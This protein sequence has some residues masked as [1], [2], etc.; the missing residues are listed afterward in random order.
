MVLGQCGHSICLSCIQQIAQLPTSEQRCPTC[1]ERVDPSNCTPNH[2]L[3]D[4][5]AAMAPPPIVQAPAS[6]QPEELELQ[7]QQE[8]LQQQQAI[9]P[10]PFEACPTHGDRIRFLCATHNSL[11]CAT[12]FL[13]D[14]E[15]CDR[16]PLEAARQQLEKR[17]IAALNDMRESG[18]KLQNVQMSLAERS[19]A[20]MA[21]RETVK[22]EVRAFF[23]E[24]RTERRSDVHLLSFSRP[25]SDL[26]ILCVVCA[27]RT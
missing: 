26:N 4:T 25:P 9:P 15:D 14:H 17:I 1:R 19:S 10:N 5:L 27:V 16:H 24:V 3:R 18:E 21:R 23:A 22:T 13:E 6:P 8:A 20:L 2:A 11:C 12:C 7:Q